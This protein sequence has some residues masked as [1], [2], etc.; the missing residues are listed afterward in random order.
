MPSI[1]QPVPLASYS[2]APVRSNSQLIKLGIKTVP[3]GIP[4][5]IEVSRS[6]PLGEMFVTALRSDNALRGYA[7]MLPDQFVRW[8]DTPHEVRDLNAFCGTNAN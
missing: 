7:F 5:W 1:A 8:D 4:I 3:A 6:A 2:H